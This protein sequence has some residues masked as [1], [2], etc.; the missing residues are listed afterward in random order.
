MPERMIRP[1]IIS[2]ERVNALG[3]AAEVF[4]RRLF[5]IVDDYGCY[6]GR[7]AILRAALYPLK[8]DK[9]GDPD[10]DKWKLETAEAGLVR[11]YMVEGKEF[12]Q[13]LRFDQRLRGKPKWPEP[14]DGYLPQPAANC[15]SS[16]PSSYSSSSANSHS[17]LSYSGEREKEN[18]LKPEAIGP[19]KTALEIQREQRKRA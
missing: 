19:R 11:S 6:D 12:I 10:V 9:V 16:P 3:W 14:P 8:L 5:S 18:Q 2:S 7:S 17:S 15:G 4:Y 1:G 13:V